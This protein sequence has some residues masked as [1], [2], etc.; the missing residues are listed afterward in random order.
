MKRKGPQNVVPDVPVLYKIRGYV[1]VGVVKKQDWCFK[2]QDVQNK[3]IRSCWCCKKQ[4]EKQEEDQRSTAVRSSCR[5][6]KLRAREREGERGRER[7]R[8]RARERER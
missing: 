5:F 2:K 8:E 4:E 6:F 3:R 7:E 1:V